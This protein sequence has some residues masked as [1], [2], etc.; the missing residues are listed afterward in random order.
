MLQLNTKEYKAINKTIK[1]WEDNHLIDLDTS[2]KLRHSYKRIGFDWLRLSKY[3]FWISLCCASLAI[4]SFFT[5]NLFAKISSAL[6]NA[7]PLSVVSFNLFFAFIFY[8]YAFKLRKNHPEQRLKNESVIFIGALFT[9]VSICFVGKFF[10]IAN[11]EFSWLLLLAVLLYGVLALCFPSKLLWIL[12]LFVLGG[13]FTI[14]TNYGADYGYYDL[15]MNYSLR[16]ALLGIALILIN[17][18]TTRFN[19]IRCLKQFNQTTSMIGLLYLFIGIWILSIFGNCGSA[20]TCFVMKQNELLLWSILLAISAL[21]AILYGIKI[22]DVI[23]KRFGLVF[24]FINLYT[25][26]FEFFWQEINKTLFFIILGVSFWMLGSKAE[27][28]VKFF[29][30]N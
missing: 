20:N 12:T 17:E 22:N 25:Q 21:T 29:K 18:I 8:L 4:V 14:V 6:Q 2:C 23:Y 27:K 3:A 11:H 15:R 1:Y 26:Y 9:G 10:L 19:V 16:F 30:L 5:S 28:M 13:W 24:F 7:A